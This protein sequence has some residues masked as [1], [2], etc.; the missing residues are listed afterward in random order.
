MWRL[1]IAPAALLVA[2]AGCGPAD[3]ADVPPEPVEPAR[4][5]TLGDSYSSGQGIHRDASDLDDHGPPA[6]SFD[7]STRLGG[8]ACHRELDTTPGPRIADTAGLD[9]VF[10]ACAGASI[11]D[12]ANQVVAAD[13]P[14]DGAGTIVALTIGGNDA[15]T[16]EGNDWPAVLLECIT[17]FGC[18][19]E[20]GGIANADE[21][22]ERLAAALDEMLDEYPRST[23]RVLAYPELAQ[24]DRWGCL[25]I[26][27]VGRREAEWIDEQSVRLNATLERAV[28]DTAIR[29]DADLAFVA[30]AEEFEGH[31]A[32]RALQRDRYVNDVLKGER[33]RRELDAEGEV[34]DVYEDG[35]FTI[36]GSSF[37][38]SQAG[39]DAYLRALAADLE[40]LLADDV[41]S[42]TPSD[43]TE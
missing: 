28:D 16:A 14:A 21:I 43:L 40:P 29:T 4:L 20:D 8:S 31:G 37:H 34:V 15:R 3:G 13:I 2:S 18:D 33:Y 12:I 1:I 36:S 30:V 10:V 27:G 24:P 35:A 32:C 22:E 11:A 19:D 7:P 9:S 38:P 25:G 39:Y 26:P 42:A 17:S 6:H 5:I 41:S 23:I